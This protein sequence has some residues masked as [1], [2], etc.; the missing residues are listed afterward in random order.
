L[1]W[2]DVADQCQS[3][4]VGGGMREVDGG[5]NGTGAPNVLMDVL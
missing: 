5:Q 2:V 4:C 1:G 3:G